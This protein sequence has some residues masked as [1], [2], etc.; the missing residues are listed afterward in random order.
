MIEIWLPGRFSKRPRKSNIKS[1]ILLA[2]EEL[3]RLQSLAGEWTQ[4]AQYIPLS[5][6]NESKLGEDIDT[7]FDDLLSRDVD[8]VLWQTHLGARNP[9]AFPYLVRCRLIAS[10]LLALSGQEKE[11]YLL[12]VTSPSVARTLKREILKKTKRQVCL[13]GVPPLWIYF[14]ALR[15]RQFVHALR[16][17]KSIILTKKTKKNE[18]PSRHSILLKTWV[19]QDCINRP[20]PYLNRNFG[21]FQNFLV[22]ENRQV[23]VWP[24]FHLLKDTK[25]AAVAKLRDK[26]IK[27]IHD[28]ELLR[29]SPSL[30]VVSRLFRASK[31][32]GNAVTLEIDTTDVLRECHLQ[33][34]IYQE[35]LVLASAGAVLS[36]LKN[37][38]SLP[39]A[40]YFPYESNLAEN[41]LI[42]EV[43]R[44]GLETKLL[45]FQHS[46]WFRKHSGM[47]LSKAL[48]QR[49]PFPDRIIT[50]GH[51]YLRILE[52]AGYPRSILFEGCNLRFTAANRRDEPL[53]DSGSRDDKN[54]LAVLIHQFPGQAVAMI[55]WIA[56][57]G[58]LSRRYRLLLKPHPALSSQWLEALCHEYGLENFEIVEGPIDQTI[59]RSWAVLTSRSSVSYLEIISSG[60]LVIVPC[61]EA[62]IDLDTLW[63]SA[64]HVIFAMEPEEIVRIAEK[65]SSQKLL[66]REYGKDVGRRY[67]EPVSDRRMTSFSNF[68]ST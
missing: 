18:L 35:S 16:F 38:E 34:G 23:W 46:V 52:F 32:Q 57:R 27:V 61:L 2:S 54:S 67:F 9:F 49:Q 39:G 41:A 48:R 25:S 63:E 42:S 19:T 29:L 1:T 47:E 24:Q 30:K 21:E 43:R 17:L 62:V 7:V 6:D 22:H 51:E 45:A 5:P 36:E 33:T 58:A 15:G 53:N 11:N 50:S 59:A 66:L 13:T 3:D 28:L 56:R 40:I 26:G 8:G 55:R 64:S 12:L 20:A 31:L 68:I 44:M 65:S 37:Q 4:H 14:A 10:C 60:H